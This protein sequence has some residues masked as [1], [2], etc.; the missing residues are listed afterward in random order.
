MTGTTTASKVKAAAAKKVPVKKA[1]T[2]KVS[3]KAATTKV[4]PWHV[5]FKSI[6]DKVVHIGCP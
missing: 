4:R 5:T 2:S 3:T 1:A 6:S